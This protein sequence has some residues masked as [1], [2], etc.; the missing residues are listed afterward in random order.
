M[1]LP[2]K[3]KTR[4]LMFAGLGVLVAAG[5]CAS[6]AASAAA[7][8]AEARTAAATN[9]SG[10]T[11]PGT[12]PKLRVLINADT[13]NEV[14]DLYAIARALI[15]PSMDVIGLSSAQWQVSHYATPNTLEDSQRL[16][17]ALLALLDKSHIP[18]P[19]GAS[20]RL[21]DWGDVAQH[22]AAAHQIIREAHRTPAGEK[23]TVVMLGATTDLASALLI[24]P[25]IRSKLRVYLLGTSYD[26][27]KKV[28]RK[29]DFNCVMDIQAIEV[30][31]DAKDLETHILPV[32]VAAA[33]EFSLEEVRQ[34]FAGRNESLDLLHRR[35]LDHM[36]G[37][38]HRRTIWD[39]ALISCLIRPEFGE[40]V[41]V[42]TPPENTPREVRVYSRIDGRRIREEFFAALGKHYG[43]DF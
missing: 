11:L 7:S 22:S 10:A 41:T 43:L 23:L 15:E 20:A 5:A 26:F 8:T 24:D 31:L 30:V 40:E 1:H 6:V 39:L 38:R 3:T 32:N 2:M 36:D 35:W 21:H 9:G 14:D 42:T 34:K 37:G 17:E 25:A 4:I 27:E 16:N 12:S 19:R 29:R 18:H 13:A 28:W 33:M